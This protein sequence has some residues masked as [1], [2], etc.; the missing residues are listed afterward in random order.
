MHSLTESRTTRWPAQLAALTHIALPLSL[1]QI[2]EM[3]MGVTDNILLGGIGAAALAVGGLS[4]GLFFVTLVTFQAGLGGVSVLI[5]RARGEAAAGHRTQGGNF[6]GLVSAGFACALL[7]CVPVLAVLLPVGAIFRAFGEP[8]A[9]LVPGTRFMHILLGSLFPDL[10]V[11][12]LLRIVLPA[13]GSE[14]LLLATMPFMALVNGVMNAALIH[15]WLG[16][17]ALGLWGSAVASCVTGWL[18]AFLLVA[19]CWRQAE[20]RPHLRLVRPQWPVMRTMLRLGLPLTAATGAEVAAF[21]ITGLRAGHFGTDALAAHQVAV[22]V[23][24]LLFMMSLALSQAANVRVAYWLGA[25]DRRAAGR[26]AWGAMG[27]ALAWSVVSGGLL[28]ACPAVI[29]GVYLDTTSPGGASAAAIAVK[30]LRI[31]AVYQIFDGLQVTA[32]GALR[33]CHDTLVPMVLIVISYTLCTFIG[34]GWLADA[35]GLGVEGLW[36]GLAG[37]LVAVG[38]LLPI[39]LRAKLRRAA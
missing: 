36:Y 12:G 14:R 26:A 22:S 13:F 5:A 29:A 25:G 7:L 38:I 30:L 39:R 27:L 6:S 15:G 21:Q 10:V 33:A 3:A 31:A 19:L 17:P 32:A 35:Q 28:L 23:T 2:S 24:S 20:L 34:G 11:I 4:T 37:G 16:L 18:I 9:I 1:S 8:E